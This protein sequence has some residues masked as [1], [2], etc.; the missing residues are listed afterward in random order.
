M[1]S[2][3]TR[4]KHL[5]K[6]SR[7]L[8]EIITNYATLIP[9]ETPTWHLTQRRCNKTA[10]LRGM[11]GSKNKYTIETYFL[12]QLNKMTQ[13]HLQTPARL[14]QRRQDPHPKMTHWLASDNLLSGR[15]NDTGSPYVDP[16]DSLSTHVR[17]SV[18]RRFLW[19]SSWCFGSAVVLSFGYINTHSKWRKTHT[20]LCWQKSF[21]AWTSATK[22]MKIRILRWSKFAC[23]LG[24]WLDWALP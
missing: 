18:S 21:L 10:K 14:I 6:F 20:A 9:M 19:P 23:L 2:L 16:T 3:N 13:F 7:L 1:L 4:L 22:E 17:T 11:L 8:L 5:M 24:G 15:C 12:P